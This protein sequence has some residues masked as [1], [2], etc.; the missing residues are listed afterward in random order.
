[1]KTLILSLAASAALVSAVKAA[2][3][4]PPKT[5]ESVASAS[6]SAKP[7]KASSSD[8]KMNA[9]ASGQPAV[10][11]V[12][13]LLM[14]NIDSPNWPAAANE[15]IADAQAGTLTTNTVVN[16]P[17]NYAVCDY[18]IVWQ[19]LIESTTTPMWDGSLNPS[20]PFNNELGGPLIWQLLDARAASGQNELSL[21]MLSLTSSSSD[22]NVLGG[23]IGFS[24]DSYSAR[25]IAIKADGTLINEGDASQKGVRV[26]V[27]I[28][29]KLFNGGDTLSGIDSVSNWVTAPQRSPYSITYTAIVGGDSAT[30][31]VATVS[32]VTPPVLPA[33]PT[34]SI[35]NNG[36]RSGTI[37]LKGG[38]PSEQYQILCAVSMS[39][40]W[41]LVGLATADGGGNGSFAITPAVSA[42]FY[43]AKAQ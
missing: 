34:L 42:Q 19:N 9:L 2:E 33:V 13:P 18:R 6:V 39:G 15:A 29:M 17:T 10:V 7:Q 5:G 37:T 31:S 22:G 23:A 21:D 25:A 3:Q 8:I 16:V 4:T 43:R 14:V 27:L 11:A 30:A 40:P 20:A 26:L 1:M 38:T 35:V 32:T 41:S 12:T 28:C 24:G 36:N